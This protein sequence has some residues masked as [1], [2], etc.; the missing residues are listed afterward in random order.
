LISSLQEDRF[1][2]FF[3][4]DLLPHSDFARALEQPYRLFV[5]DQIGR[6]L[7]NEDAQE[8][9]LRRAQPERPKTLNVIDQREK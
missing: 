1:S 5:R 7:V 2:H 3:S 9:H 6:E 8:E 4:D